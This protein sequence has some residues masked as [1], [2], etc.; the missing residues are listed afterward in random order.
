MDAAGNAATQA[1]RTVTVQ[2]PPPPDTTPPVIT[3]TGAN[4]QIITTGNAYTELGATAADDVDGD[5]TASIVPDSSAVNTAVAG[6]YTV[7][8]NVMD[9]AGNAATEATRTVTVQDPPVTPPPA[10]RSSGGCSIGPSDGMID[11]TLPILMLIS[12]VYMLR[13]RLSEI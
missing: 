6:S 11:P 3:V 7:T 8:Y 1:T 5:L 2:D 10:P 13:R 12:L 9:A 4:P